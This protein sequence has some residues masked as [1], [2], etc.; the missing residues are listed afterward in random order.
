MSF[1]ASE[2]SD[3]QLGK[4]GFQKAEMGISRLPAEAN[5]PDKMKIGELADGSTAVNPINS[6]LG[7]KAPLDYKLDMTT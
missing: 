6:R 4:A 3:Q 1:S 2:N 5:R 7:S